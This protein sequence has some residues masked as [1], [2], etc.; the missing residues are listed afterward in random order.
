LTFIAKRYAFLRTRGYAT[1]Q[2][3]TSIGMDL[4]RHRVGITY[5]AEAENKP[6]DHEAVRTNKENLGVCH[7]YCV[8]LLRLFSNHQFF[9]SIHSE[10]ERTTLQ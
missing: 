10:P 4:L 7:I 6:S 2:D 1:P 5:E 3:V 8:M 9:F